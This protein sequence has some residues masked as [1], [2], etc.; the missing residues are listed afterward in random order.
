MSFPLGPAVFLSCAVAVLVTKFLKNRGRHPLPP[1]PRGLPL[2]G[3][4]LQLPVDHEWFTFAKWGKLYGGVVYVSAFGRPL[5]ILNS[6]KAITDLLEKRSGIYSDRPVLPM[7]GEMVGYRDSVP[8]CPY[9]ARHRE[10][11]KLMHGGLALSK[12]EELFPVQEQKMR[13]FLH[14]LLTAPEKLPL[15]I[16]Q[17]VAA[18][19]F[20]ISHGY[21]VRD[22]ND[23]LV[24]LAERA[25]LEFSLATA[26]GAFVVD[27]LPVL[28]YIPDWF[29]GAGFK[30][31]AK[32]WRQTAIRL[33]DDPYEHIKEQVE[34][35]VAVPSFTTS[36]V[37]RN[38]NPTP[39]EEDIYKWASA[40]FYSGGAD[41]SVS[42]ISSFFLAM[43]LHPDVQR[44][45]RDELIR[46]VGSGR[47]PTFK[48]RDRLPYINALLKE[49]LR[50]NPVAPL[51]LPHRLIQDDVYEG[52][53]LPAGSIVFANTWGI[54]KDP[55]LYPSPDEFK[56]ERYLS[57]DSGAVPDPRSFAFGY[58]RR[59]C[60]GQH[61][62]DATLYLTIVSTLFLY[63]I[64]NAT[65]K[66]T[67]LPIIPVPNYKAGVICHPEEYECLIKPVYSEAETLTLL[68]K[69]L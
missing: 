59:I 25:T 15:H 52:Y 54:F 50:W 2:I 51:A 34:K 38:A 21:T 39:E 18:I 4:A 17:V 9:G 20:Q 28:Q 40:G 67:G 29:P 68:R 56:P 6:T 10:S 7:A 33:K 42:A 61:L 19:V 32:A 62:A 49:V 47:L 13:D 66:K 35:G 43:V 46:V 64:T 48:D 8:L 23:P 30:K 1:G 41:T 24:E 3:N 27:L 16:R 57:S 53:H 22:D 11:R 26:P 63:E 44:K 12:M 31:T 37:E 5:I 45:A 58:G 60:P 55:D 14:S 65:D 69:G 36:L